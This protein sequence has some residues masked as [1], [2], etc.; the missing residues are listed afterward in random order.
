MIS[1][2]KYSK[3]ST[4]IKYGGI[5]VTKKFF[6]TCLMICMLIPIIFGCTSEQADLVEENQSIQQND[7][8][9]VGGELKLPIVRFSTMNPILNDSKDIYYLSQFIYDGLVRLDGQHQAQPALAKSWEWSESENQWIFHLRE[10][11]KWHDNSIFS[12]RD[13]EFTIHVLQSSIGK[14]NESIYSERVKH[15]TK[16]KVIDDYTIAIQLNGA[17]YRSV[18]AFTFPI[19]PRHQFK[20]IQDVY[21]QEELIPVGTGAYKIDSYNKNRRIQLIANDQYWGEKPYIPSI[22]LEIVP[23]EDAALTLLEANELSGAQTNTLDWEKYSHNKSLKIHEYITQDYE[24]LGFNFNKPLLQ[25]KHIRKALA[26]GIDRHEIIERVYL[27]HATL[28]DA[29]ISPDSW[30]YKEEQKKYGR[31]DSKATQFLSLAGWSNQD[32]DPWLENQEGQELTLNLL[33]NEDNPQR[34]QAAE[35]IAAHLEEIGIRIEV[36][37]VSTEEYRK[38]IFSGRFDIV[39]AGWQFSDVFDLRFALHSSYRSNTNFIAYQNEKMDQ[40]L[41]EAALAT[42]P[43]RKQEVY[44][45]IQKLFIEDLPYLS[46]YFKN[47]ALIL[48]KDIKGT[49]EPRAY[50]IYNQIENWYISSQN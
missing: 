5:P 28:T 49:I 16:V 21:Q 47:G 38:R 13:V 33:V 29:P 44:Q 12:A 50:R 39:L 36:D 30:L 10:N 35:I 6:F 14:A 11:V 46:L 9:S 26:Y 18:E 7:E 34:V 43:N 22:Y 20:T 2:K 1:L 23:D 27:G 25:N 3:S 17:A 19:I 15:I 31:D 40:F 4:E 45:E 32:E 41:T 42:E 37:A 48:H 24:F 8:P